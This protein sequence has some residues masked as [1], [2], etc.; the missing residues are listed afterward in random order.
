MLT[1]RMHCTGDV[2]SSD[3]IFRFRTHASVIQN[4]QRCSPNGPRISI[5]GC[6]GF[7]TA[8][9]PSESR[10]SS[11]S[12]SSLGPSICA[13]ATA[14]IVVGFCISASASETPLEVQNQAS[15]VVVMVNI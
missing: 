12:C 1:P 4:R 7:H 11:H 10:W 3:S 9:P 6:T 2:N 8:M 15:V 13:E 5:R 14:N